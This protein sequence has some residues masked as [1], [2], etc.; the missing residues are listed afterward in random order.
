MHLHFSSQQLAHLVVRVGCLACV[1]HL[2]V[3]WEVGKLPEAL[4]GDEGRLLQGVEQ[5]ILALAGGRRERTGFPG[6]RVAT[7]GSRHRELLRWRDSEKWRE[8]DKLCIIES[9]MGLSSFGSMFSMLLFL[10]SASFLS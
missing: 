3:P 6:S 9:T 10:C 2:E 7:G 8:N 4:L 5:R 1:E